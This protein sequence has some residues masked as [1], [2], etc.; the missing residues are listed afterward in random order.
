MIERSSMDPK[1]RVKYQR[2]NVRSVVVDGDIARVDLGNGHWATI[3]ASDT[4]L[5]E[6]WNWR[7]SRSRSGK[8]YAIRTVRNDLGKNKN[9]YMH[10]VV[11]GHPNI[12]GFVTDHADGDPLNN[13]RG[14]LRHATLQQNARN[15]SATLTAAGKK[16]NKGVY[17]DKRTNSYYVVFQFGCFATADAAS[18]AYAEADHMLFGE[19]SLSARTA[20][21]KEAA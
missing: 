10:K 12:A 2:R 11:S 16:R 7:A 18:L 4:A 17:F 19:F 9:I 5:I 1:S 14:N 8:Y 20:N 21:K 15:R 6:G 13:R 3:D